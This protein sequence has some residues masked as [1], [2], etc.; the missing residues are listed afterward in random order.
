MRSGLRRAITTAW[1]LLPAT[2]AAQQ[3]QPPGTS[4]ETKGTRIG[5]YGFGVRS[6]IDF[7]DNGQ[8]IAGMSLDLGNLFTSRL[9]LRPSAEIGVFNGVNT[10][11]ASFET[12]FRFTDDR[13][14]TQPYFG[15]GFSIAGR[16]DCGT[17]SDCPAL[18]ANLV[19]GLELHYRSTF[20]WLLEY[21]GMDLL[22]RHRLYVGLTT[23]RGN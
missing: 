12:L 18:W 16:E 5:L 9:R 17:V 21:H 2:L 19:L 6:G 14:I 11:V 1:V 7:G 10:Y 20:N 15:G 23:R 8:F 4:S 3:F 13:Q 22:R